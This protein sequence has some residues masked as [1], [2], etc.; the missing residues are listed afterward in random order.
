MSALSSS[1]RVLVVA[2]LIVPVGVLLLSPPL[3][4]SQAGA[5]PQ[6][7]SE[8]A[9]LGPQIEEARRLAREGSYSLVVDL[10]E[11]LEARELVAH[12]T[13]RLILADA[14]WRA[15]AAGSGDREDFSRARQELSELLEEA[16][17]EEEMAPGDEPSELPALIEESL[18]DSWWLPDTQRNWG[19]AWQYWSSA[20]ARWAGWKEIEP[21][22]ERYL[23]IVFKAASSTDGASPVERWGW[24]GQSLPLEVLENAIEIAVDV[25]SEAHAH[26]L[27]GLA[28]RSRSQEARSRRALVESFERVLELGDQSDWYD[29]AL[30]AYAQWEGQ[31][32]TFERRRD[33][34]VEVSPDWERALEL[35]R[36]LVRE[37]RPGE[38]PFRRV[39]QGAIT[40]ITEE[41]L[42][43]VI[44][45]SFLPGSPLRFY[46]GWRNVDQAEIEL[47]AVDLLDMSLE[48]LQPSEDR[49]EGGL[50]STL[51]H[52]QEPAHREVVSLA[53]GSAHVPGQRQIWIER[54]IPTGAYLLV[55]RAG[56]LERRELLLVTDL[57]VVTKSAPGEILAFV[58]GQERG[59][60]VAGAELRLLERQDSNRWRER[61]AV[62]GSNGLA[63]LADLDGTRERLLF[64]RSGARQ[65]L[66]RAW[67]VQ[68]V[69]EQPWRVFTL[70]DRPAYRPGEEAFFKLIARRDRPEGAGYR[71]PAGE[72]VSYRIR[73]PRGSEVAAG[74]LTLGEFGSAD[75]SLTLGGE[76]TL[77]LYH[78][79]LQDAGGDAI[80]A[81]VLFRL[82]EYRLPEFEVTVATGASASAEAVRPGDEIA[83]E[84]EARY[85]FGAPVAGATVELVVHRTPYWRPYRSPRPYPWLGPA[86]ESHRLV[87]P[88]LS[89]SVIARLAGRTDTRGTAHFTVGS[90]LALDGGLGYRYR[91]EARVTDVSRREVV[92]QASLAVTRDPYFVDLE[93]RHRIYRPGDRAE[94]DVRALD[95][96]DRPVSASGRVLVSREVWRERWVDARGRTVRSEELER[97]RSRGSVPPGWRPVEGDFESEEVLSAPFLISDSEDS[98]VSFEV[99]EDGFY[100]VLWI[101]DVDEPELEDPVRAQ[102]GLYVGDPETRELGLRH[103]GLDLILDRSS[104][105][106]GSRLPLLLSADTPGRWVLLTVEGEEL[107]ETRVVEMQGQA[108]FLSLELLPGYAPNVTV[109]ALTVTDAT[110]RT[111][112]EELEVAPAKRLLEV[113]VEAERER[114][115]PG[116][117]GA[118]EVETRDAGG[119]PVSAEV[120]LAVVDDAVFAI[121]DDLA[122][123]I[124]RFFHGQ[125]RPLRVQTSSS[126]QE[127]PL[128]RVEREAPLSGEEVARGEKSG[129][130][131]GT[132]VA[133]DAVMA[134]SRYEAE[135]AQ[136]AR[137]SP[138]PSP[139][140][141]RARED[142]AGSEIAVRADFRATALWLPDV[143]TDE[144]GQARLDV[145]FP[146]SLT[147]WRIVARAVDRSDR[148]G[149]ATTTTRTA[150]RLQLRLQTPRFL[151]SGD[152][153]VLSTSIYN[154]GPETR[155]VR[156]EIE[157]EG[158]LA[159]FSFEPLEI[160][161]AAGDTQIDFP[162]HAAAAGAATVT[163]TVRSID[164]PSLGDAV[165]RTLPIEEHGLE[166][167]LT[168]TGVLDGEDSLTLE[169]DLPTARRR[170]ST[171]LEIRVVSSPAL[172][173]LDALPFL[174]D[175][176]Y[177][178]TEQTLSRFLPTVITLRTLERLGVDRGRLARRLFEERESFGGVDPSARATQENPEERQSSLEELD[179]MVA[180]G[181]TRL[182]ELQKGDGSW[183][184]F[185][186]GPSDPWMTAYALW[187]LALAGEAGVDVDRSLLDR[188]DRFLVDRLV[189]FER[190]PNLQAFLLHAVVAYRNQGR[191]GQARSSV[192]AA[193][194]NLWQ[195]RDRLAPLGR[196]LF[197]MTAQ[198]RNDVERAEVLVRN[199]ENGARR[200][201][202]RGGTQTVRWGESQGWWRWWNGA[203]ESTAFSLMALVGTDPGH[204]LV[205]PAM[206]WLVENRR[207]AHWNNTRD[208][209][210]SILALADYLETSRTLESD[211][212]FEVLLNG[213]SLGRHAIVGSDAL[214]RAPTRFL[215]PSEQIGDG[216]H[217]VEVVRLS[218]GERGSVSE[219]G[220]LWVTASARFFSL[221][222]PIAPA[223]TRVAVARMYARRLAQETLLDG[224]R[225]ESE[226]LAPGQPVASGERL[227]IEV[228]LELANEVEYLMIEDLKPAGLE[229][230]LVRSGEALWAERLEDVVSANGQT[231][232]RVV[233]QRFVYQELRDRKIALFADRLGQGRWRIRYEMRAETP[234][235]FHALPVT[236]E[237][238][239]VPE[240][241][242]NGAESELRVVPREEADL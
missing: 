60:P 88:R 169:I 59:E 192:D 228:E 194:Q 159:S 115:E 202:F 49:S 103:G 201:R 131:G 89:G 16:L 25:E 151:V 160:E 197:L 23:G 84:V 238:M 177:G 157:S 62:T 220:P 176:P 166:K 102:V 189:E 31:Q 111:D 9:D 158:D 144:S 52:G 109:S 130:D 208:S 55:A 39:A 240:L 66:S 209:A 20:L 213:R 18:G 96:E 212:E 232:E 211:V 116:D 140:P 218:G 75:A 178:C 181:L 97:R 45:E 183:P 2:A 168:D 28:L 51:E 104:A 128:V 191:S 126:L 4:R 19:Q 226:P 13:A 135:G 94:V 171:G 174:A 63:Q 119:D 67:A 11:G 41:R 129:F 99:E 69:V 21:A 161:V 163:A 206:S 155:R 227:E 237:A 133:A 233:E 121:E 27:R 230:V 152:Q 3:A 93:P 106:T 74:E 180:K 30:Y 179:A 24:W 214:T 112:S 58:A 125:R 105:E 200:E 6:G 42:D 242:A 173:M 101:S 216:R 239:Y 172:A 14:R 108:R 36:R 77:G 10:L 110:V 86:P 170:E 117:T 5:Q 225:F 34:S 148:V 12:P 145:E 149:E 47:H 203:V 82:E 61:R 204:P 207:G 37:T 29:D 68:G 195:E 32:G 187:G 83:V 91:M 54:E 120:A 78:I 138:S 80:G 223:S 182:A 122:G 141:S 123:D 234:G 26:L 87:S 118:I 107:F 134:E 196:A 79:E 139:E 164:D 219:A 35:Y 222:E 65:T 221:E 76:A 167:L 150:K 188:A 127:R 198:S 205:E 92:G 46:L 146:D 154:E 165:R 215:V 100:R 33:G 185:E 231:H 162:V 95:G 156:L 90:E 98:R 81:A 44:G 132:A 193:F 124:R 57:V 48:D 53:V 241:R 147:A 184:W 143:R 72:R 236:V 142:E 114:Y 56:S 199:L 175:Y 136:L 153:G 50:W 229:A 22:R 7:P 186:G 113:V 235:I 40:E 17:L 71:T 38:S 224:V 8:E 64:V 73:D 15:A 217:E 137:Q 85:Y 43:L 210:I 1:S 190:E 70:T